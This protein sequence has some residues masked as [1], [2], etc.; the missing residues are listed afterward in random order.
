LEL[1]KANR[2]DEDPAWSNEKIVEVFDV[3][4]QTNEKILK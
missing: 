2:S 3:I 4:V 1:L